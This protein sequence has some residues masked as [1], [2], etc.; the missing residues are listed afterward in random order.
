M[1]SGHHSQTKING[2]PTALIR[3]YL[4]AHAHSLQKMRNAELE[5]LELGWH[6]EFVDL[7]PV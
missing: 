6:S 5:E 4:E 7:I 3:K 1:L 2:S